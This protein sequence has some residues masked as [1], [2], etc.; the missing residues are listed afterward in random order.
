M[1]TNREEVRVRV[2]PSPTGYLHLGTI[3]TALFNWL[4]AKKNKG[5]FVLRIEDTDKMR[6]LPIYESD[7][8]VGLKML[9]I[10]WDEGPDIGGS[11][12]P[13]RQS[14]RKNIYKKYLQKLLNDKKAFWCYCTKEEIEAEKKAMLS[15]GLPPIYSGTCRNLT[16]KE[17]ERKIKEGRSKV[18]RLFTPKNLEI[19][20][21]DMI[22]EEISVNTNTIGDFI[23]AKNLDKP[24]YNFAVV[25]DDYLMKI[26][27]VIRGEDHISNTP[28]QILIQ[29]ALEI[30]TP[31]YAHLPL[32]LSPSRSKLS[33]RDLKTSFNDY[34]RDG[35]L[36]EAIINFLALIGWNP[37][38]DTEIM[39]IS[40]MIEKF[41]IKK[42]QKGGG[43]FNTEKLNWFNSNYIKKLSIE[44]LSKR[45][46]KFTPKEWN[47]SEI[48]KRAVEVEQARIK[49]LSEFKN[50]ASFFFK[51]NN[52]LSEL[53][54]WK[55][56]SIEDTK[57]NLNK[58]LDKIKS[59]SE[60]D[61]TEKK[62][63]EI[64]MPVADKIGRGDFLWPLRIALS[65]TKSS[66]G[67]FEIMYVLGKKET[68]K[69]I[70]VAIFKLNNK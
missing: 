2:A 50:N 24:L 21:K 32:V 27:H 16:E 14:E 45:L 9:N 17:R 47:K 44:E 60:E 3:R 67:P 13:Y 58:A 6:S 42:I 26:T 70:E 7:I 69:R 36:P 33:K 53:I 49:K 66:P 62:I 8:I 15:A 52:Y 56:N 51:L 59:I 68:I 18:I 22:R 46:I 41:D 61:F 63:K 31:K 20:F 34:I 64:L 11:F 23:I 4:F 5:K 55:N 35:Y 1:A 54:I 30:K 57:E 12:G 28:K 10:N 29:R 25:I 37:G 39:S 38:D 19:K 48:Y 40:E 65:G 43:A